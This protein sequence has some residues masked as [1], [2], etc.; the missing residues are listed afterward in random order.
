MAFRIGGRMRN[1]TGAMLMLFALSAQAQRE[2]SGA[3]SGISSVMGAITEAQIPAW[4]AAGLVP[5]LLIWWLREIWLR[6]RIRR[7]KERVESRGAQRHSIKLEPESVATSE[8][9]PL[10]ELARGIP[11]TLVETEIA[12]DQGRR[13]VYMNHAASSVLGRPPE[14]FVGQAYSR[15]LDLIHEDDLPRVL[16]AIGNLTAQQFLSYRIHHHES[17]E[18]RW[19]LSDSMSRVRDDGVRVMR[20]VLVDITS[21]KVVEERL[22]QQRDSAESAA[23]SRANFLANM[24]HEIRTPMNAIIG[25]CHLALQTELDSKQLNYLS[26]ID[27]ASRSL[28]GIVND[29]LD[30]SKIEAGKL[31]MELANFKL[32]DLL[33]NLAMLVGQMIQDKGLELLFRISPDIPDALI[34]DPLRLGQILTNFSSNAAKFTESGEIVVSAEIEE[35]RGDELYLRFEVR[36]TG[37]G[38]D[39]QARARLFKAFEQADSSTTRRFGGTGLGLAIASS[40]AEMMGGKVGVESEVGK[41]ST[42]WFTVRLKAQPETLDTDSQLAIGAAGRRVLIV[43]DNATA[44]EVLDI[45]C[46][47]QSMQTTRCSSGQEAMD[48]LKKAESA[49]AYDLVLLDWNMPG[50]DGVQTARA[51]RSDLNLAK[52]PAIIMITGNNPEDLLN[53]IEDLNVDGALVKPVSAALLRNAIQNALGL[54]APVA[55]AIPAPTV[56]SHAALKGK[57]V[58]LVEDNE[59]NQ[60]IALEVLRQAGLDVMLADNGQQAVERV[61]ENAFDIVLMDMQMPVMDGISASREIRRDPQLESL[62]IL[63]MTANVLDEDIQRCFDA[64]MNDHVAK[65][66]DVEEMLSKLE[67]WIVGSGEGHDDHETRTIML[68]ARSGHLPSVMDGLDLDVALKNMVGNRALVRKLLIKFRETHAGAIERLRDALA[69]EDSETAIRIA[70]TLKAVAGNIGA[71]DLQRAAQRIESDLKRNL[72]VAEQLPAMKLELQRVLDSIGK[73]DATTTARDARKAPADRFNAPQ[74]DKL[75]AE[76]DQLLED[77]DIAAT[78]VVDRIADLGLPGNSQTLVRSLHK[79]VSAYDFDAA[80]ESLTQLRSQIETTSA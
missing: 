18:L 64:G 75:L 5:L 67:M 24:S 52:Q 30:V 38:I 9:A 25:M 69:S 31:K 57:R 65:P 15:F 3:A 51:I 10:S 77:D 37:I 19:L 40:L 39:P 7:I 23:A 8:S 50:F 45:I 54:T 12:P 41:G 62:P 60:E 43:D 2:D 49:T 21:I 26:K 47:A 17:G 59:I 66:I 46:R 27:S 20:G 36:D 44:Q 71:A 22:E 76:L 55:R 42:F 29:V 16:D 11:A 32:S 61:R 33:D 63:A 28:L 6:V 56:S 74:L 14:Y 13:I 80:R 78:D 58:L 4:I 70:H 73:L 53:E 68:P 48:L 35:R 1:L 79:S 72:N 34:G